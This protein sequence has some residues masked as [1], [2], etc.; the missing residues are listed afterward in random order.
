MDLRVLFRI[1]LKVITGKFNEVNTKYGPIQRNNK[2]KAQDM[3]HLKICSR[4]G[5]GVQVTE[6]LLTKQTSTAR[7]QNK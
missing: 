5:E 4:A 1:C 2:D 6:C 3:S 7:K